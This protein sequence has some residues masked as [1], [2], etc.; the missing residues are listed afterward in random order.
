MYKH[1]HGQVKAPLRKTNNGALYQFSIFTFRCCFRASMMSDD[2]CF[3]SD[4][5]REIAKV[6]LTLLSTHYHHVKITSSDLCN[7]QVHFE[8][9]SMVSRRKKI[10]NAFIEPSTGFESHA[11]RL[12]M[13]SYLISSTVRE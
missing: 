8:N 4:M 10:L 9:H 11:K 3:R 7:F 5:E 1:P 6:L 13:F 12:A 2:H